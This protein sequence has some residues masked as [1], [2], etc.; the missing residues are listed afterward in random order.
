MIPRLNPN[1]LNF[2]NSIF[3]RFLQIPTCCGSGNGFKYFIF[4]S[5]RAFS[6]RYEVS[7][8]I[9]GVDSFSFDSKKA[10]YLSVQ[11]LLSSNI[12]LNHLPRL[13]NRDLT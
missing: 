3:H 1:S 11:T 8:S 9:F 13:K 5:E 12:T 6:Q 2:K 4:S 7:P 10:L